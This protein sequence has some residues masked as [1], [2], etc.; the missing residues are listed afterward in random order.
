M[1]NIYFLI[2]DLFVGLACEHEFPRGD[3]SDE[4][5]FGTVL[6]M[7]EWM[8]GEIGEWKKPKIVFTIVILK[9]KHNI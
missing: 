4:I 1:A 2:K 9:N 5:H 6:G 7:C 3:A 8:S